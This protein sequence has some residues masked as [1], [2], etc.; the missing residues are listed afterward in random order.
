MKVPAP[1]MRFVTIVSALIMSANGAAATVR[2]VDGYT[3]EKYIF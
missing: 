1:V 2:V 3:T